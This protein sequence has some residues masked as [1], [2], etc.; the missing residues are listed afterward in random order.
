MCS[1]YSNLLQLRDGLHSRSDRLVLAESCTAGLVAAE[2]GQIPGISEFLCG[3][4]VVYRTP[5]K[6]AWL[7][8]ST[9]LLD[10]PEIGPVSAQVTI[11]LAESALAKT[12]EATIAAAITGHLGPGSPVA[13]DGKVF[14]AFVRRSQIETPAECRN[15][16]LTSPTP[17]DQDDLSRRSARQREA[18]GLLIRFIIESAFSPDCS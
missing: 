9:S 6:S 17:T 7:G 16:Q 8:I 12:P 4:M 14:C 15:Y 2:L 3:S 10:N 18:A 5:T 1:L 11:A 13:L